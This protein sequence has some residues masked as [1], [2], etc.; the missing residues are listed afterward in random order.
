MDIIWKSFSYTKV[1]IIKIAIHNTI[2]LIFEYFAIWSCIPEFVQKLQKTSMKGIYIKV[3]T[4]LNK[5]KKVI[6]TWKREIIINVSVQFPKS[7][8]SLHFS[9]IVYF[10]INGYKTHNI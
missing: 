5:N 6:I 8:L 2:A 1:F 4:E 7:I 10:D 9:K 3:K